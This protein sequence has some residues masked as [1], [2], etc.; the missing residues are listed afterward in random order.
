[1]YPTSFIYLYNYLFFLIFYIFVLFY[2]LILE[3]TNNGQAWKLQVSVE[4]CGHNGSDSI[5]IIFLVCI[6]NII[7]YINNE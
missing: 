4:M 2:I 3:D 7:I 5:H 1:M 6:H